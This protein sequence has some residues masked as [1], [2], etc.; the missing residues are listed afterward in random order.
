M[1]SD[2]IIASDVTM[3]PKEFYECRFVRQPRQMQA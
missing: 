1:T 3:F 2:T